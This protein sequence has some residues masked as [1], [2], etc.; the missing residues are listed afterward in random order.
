MTEKVCMWQRVAAR[1]K[2]PLFQNAF[3]VVAG[4]YDLSIFDRSTAWNQHPLFSQVALYASIDTC[5]M[6]LKRK[7]VDVAKTDAKKVKQVGYDI[8]IGSWTTLSKTCA[9]QSKIVC[10][11]TPGALQYRSWILLISFSIA[12]FFGQPKSSTGDAATKG[13]QGSTVAAKFNKEA[14]VAKLTDEQKEL[15]KL[16]IDTL[17]DSWLAHL[18]DE[19]TSSEFLNLKRFLAKEISSGK[20]VFPPMEEVYSW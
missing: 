10:S 12:S 15:L 5:N 13:V 16:E 8:L 18:K 9:M 7:A 20:K 11:S 19:V 2:N 17:H 1:G 3:R 6:S 4:S 14:W